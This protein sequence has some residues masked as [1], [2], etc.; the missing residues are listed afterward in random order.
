MH[1]KATFAKDGKIDYGSGI[2]KLRNEQPW[3]Y[4]TYITDSPGNVKLQYYINKMQFSLLKCYSLY[5][6]THQIL[7]N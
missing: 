1:S 5:Q 6:Q 7:Q 4:F 3:D 2:K